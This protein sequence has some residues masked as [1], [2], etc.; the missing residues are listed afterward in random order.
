MVSME[1]SP[2]YYLRYEHGSHKVNVNSK[3]EYGNNRWSREI[4]VDYPTGTMVY[5]SFRQMLR[6]V[7]GKN[8]SGM[9]FD[10][11]FKTDIQPIYDYVEWGELLVDTPPP[12]PK[13]V[14]GIDLKVKHKDIEKLMY[15]GYG[16]VIHYNGYNAEDVLQ[17]IYRGILARNVG[18]CPFDKKKSS[19]G[20]YVHM[21]IG[22]IL[23][24]YHRKRNKWKENE[25]SGVLD[26][27]ENGN[28]VER[29]V[30]SS[31]KATVSE[32]YCDDHSYERAKRELLEET[33]KSFAR[34]KSDLVIY[35][36]P[37]LDLLSEG[38]T[39]TH[40]GEELGLTRAKVSK[41]VKRLR[42]TAT[43]LF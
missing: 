42:A 37:V 34:E 11:Y 19:F 29:D 25:V 13:P 3:R 39:Q 23:N 10:K 24:N 36:K 33:E 6:E 2:A 30:A 40:I 28:Y 18:K 38:H 12:T 21:V 26:Y 8:V 4:S 1:S 43:E 27:D 41:I 14:L 9:T 15:S 31:N 20:H 5:S 16:K 22:C 32:S 35:V 17:E 7:V